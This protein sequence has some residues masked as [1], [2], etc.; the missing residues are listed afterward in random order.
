M[1]QD[2]QMHP[3]ILVKSNPVFQVYAIYIYV[4]TIQSVGPYFR[5]AEPFTYAQQRNGKLRSE[6]A[7]FRESA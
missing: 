1:A 4:G 7:T 6:W 3:W 5:T 2:S